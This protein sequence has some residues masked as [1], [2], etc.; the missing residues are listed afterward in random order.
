MPAGE[1]KANVVPGYHLG[2][3]AT[4]PARVKRNRLSLQRSDP[5]LAAPPR[6]NETQPALPAAGHHRQ[7]AA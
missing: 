5:K 7:P 1:V 2:R 4:K 3:A 6:C